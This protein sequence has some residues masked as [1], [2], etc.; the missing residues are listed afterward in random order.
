MVPSTV[1]L[2]VSSTVGTVNTVAQELQ[3]RYRS[4]KFLDQI[5]EALFKPRGLF[6]M[7][8]AYKPDMPDEAFLRVDT[9]VSAHD[10]A[11]SKTLTISNDPFKLKEKLSRL[12]LSSGEA[13]ESEI[14]ECAPLIYP[15]LDLALQSKEVTPS[16][17]GN[18]NMKSPVVQDYL[19]RRA[20]AEFLHNNP[21]SKLSNTL[22]PQ[23]KQHVNRFADPNH[24]VNSGSLVG[25]LTG[26]T[27]DPISKG[28]I[29]RA[30]AKAKKNGEP[31]LSAEERHDAYMGRKVRGRVTG[32]PSKAP[33]PIIC[34]ILKK[35]VIYLAI[36]NLPTK[37]EL[38]RVRQEL[39]RKD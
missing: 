20:Q 9:S 12:R 1:C 37:E 10:A 4:N 22:P 13:N 35:D 15:A 28:R 31:P 25:L 33:L 16:K 2:A 19:D 24:P 5:N 36:V 27:F 34:K 38:H 6:A 11:L 26:G 14:P 7:V 32:T 8:M 21:G 23:Q 39:E 18:L 17:F 3:R 30:E 29:R